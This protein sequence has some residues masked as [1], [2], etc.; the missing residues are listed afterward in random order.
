MT[1][2]IPASDN[3]A[4]VSAGCTDDLND[5]YAAVR[6]IG[7]INVCDTAYA[8]GA[9]GNG[10]ADDRAAIQAAITAAQAVGGTVIVPAGGD[11]L[12]SS[13]LQVTDTVR[14]TGGGRIFSASSG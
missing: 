14:I 6:V 11:F 13:P 5:L 7:G 4:D 8:G 12:I 3:I 1:Y 10:V 9:A 2:T